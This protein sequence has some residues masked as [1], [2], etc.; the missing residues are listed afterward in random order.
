MSDQPII[1]QYAIP[2]DGQ[3]HDLTMFIG[4]NYTNQLAAVRRCCQIRAE[5]RQC[6]CLITPEQLAVLFW[7]YTW[8]DPRPEH[9]EIR[10]F[11]VLRTEQF[12][13]V[14]AVIGTTPPNER[15]E[16]WHLVET[17][18]RPAPTTTIERKPE[19]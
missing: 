14:C 15:G 17:D 16:V 3:L 19:P 13:P 8:P 1:R 7:A 12:L 6:R 10:T 5:G 2:A 4:A 9:M 18:R 11:Q